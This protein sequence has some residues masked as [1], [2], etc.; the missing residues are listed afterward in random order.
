M[1]PEPTFAEVVRI[2]RAGGV[3]AAFDNDWPP[4]C[5]AEAEIAYND[6]EARTEA[7]G[8]ARDFMA[9]RNT[10]TKRGISRGCRRAGD[11]ATSKE[12][13]VHSMEP[14]DA[15]RLVWTRFEPG[16]G[17]RRCSKME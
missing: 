17:W 8:T 15:A 4:T 5:N 3:F 16:W 7:F 10:W 1:E 14:G 9:M 12:V 6:F 2:L 13:L 11:S